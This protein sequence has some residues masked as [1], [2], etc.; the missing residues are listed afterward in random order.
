MELNEEYKIQV[1]LAETGATQKLQNP[2]FMPDL[3]GAQR[4]RIGCEKLP[5]MELVYMISGQD[6]RALHS[7]IPDH[8]E[9]KKSWR[10]DSAEK[11]LSMYLRYVGLTPGYEVVSVQKIH[12]P[13]PADDQ[14]IRDLDLR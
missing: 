5:M 3:T 12:E 8:I 7:R 1:V 2:L 11:I 13:A 4:N 10:E 9:H 14:E 6:L